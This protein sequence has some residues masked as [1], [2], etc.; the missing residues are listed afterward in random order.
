MLPDGGKF[1]ATE[2]IKYL[3]DSIFIKNERTGS[4]KFDDLINGSIQNIN[5][6]KLDG[7]MFNSFIISG[8]NSL[9][10]GFVESTRDASKSINEAYSMNSK[11]FSF[12]NDTITNNNV[13]IGG[14]I[15][16]CIDNFLQFYITKAEYMENGESV[17]D[18]KLL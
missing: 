13:W 11:I 16:A 7:K 9:S 5:E 8:G 1:N 14:S 2:D 6:N 3:S 10:S 18:R 15:F 4:C 12:P 17:I